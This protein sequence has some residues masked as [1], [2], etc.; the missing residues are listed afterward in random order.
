LG[1]LPQIKRVGVG[2][3]VDGTLRHQGGFR[4]FGALHKGE[5]AGLL[6]RAQAGGAVAAGTAEHDGPQGVAIG[7]GG[8]FE[9]NIDGRTRVMDGLVA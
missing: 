7:V 5:A 4:G 1:E 8:G 9:K 6:D 3:G 2:T